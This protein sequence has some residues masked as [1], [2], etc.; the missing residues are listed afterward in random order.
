MNSV[1]TIQGIASIT[2]WLAI[3]T[4]AVWWTQKLRST[5]ENA[6]YPNKPI[7]V[8]VPFPAGGGSDTFVRILQKGIVE[9]NL[10][11]QPL[12]VI[13]QGGG[14]GT[15]GSRGVKN[16]R[17]D[18]YKIM[19][20]HNAIIT[21]KLSETVKYGPEA[22]TP[23]ALTGSMSLVI[24]VR[25]D[26]PFTNVS[27][28]VDQAKATP[29]AV[30]FGANQGA[31]AYFAALQLERSLP[32]ASFNI[33]SANGGA[34]R[35]ASLIGGHLQA[36]IFSLSE[37]LDFRS[38]EGTPAD[39]NIRAI[40]VL[41]AKR[42]E[43]IPDVMTCSEQGVPVVMSNANYW[44]APKGTS[45]EIVNHLATALE[46]AMKNKTVRSELT[47]LRVDLDYLTGAELQ[48]NLNDT[49]K[50]FESVAA[51]KQ[52]AVPDFIPWLA[53]VTGLMFL[54]M[55]AE[56]VYKPISAM[57][58]TTGTAVNSESHYIRR[59]GIAAGCFAILVAYVVSLETGLLPFAISTSIMVLST[60]L[61]MTRFRRSHWRVLLQTALLTGLGTEFVFTHIFVTALP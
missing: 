14:G 25:E 40:A 35:Y 38:P 51:R 23:I 36:A 44:W 28:L 59:P 16:S 31:P 54:W 26:S 2:I 48:A 58:L 49:I 50:S 32:G 24:I 56:S 53:T 27:E 4:L 13:N 10:L 61:L 19:C 47:R 57:G 9:D 37:Y 8:V 18:G 42:H 39:Q 1:R 55:I 17:P 30:C 6:K 7:Q 29:N 20:L 3:A 21:A 12:V 41:N 60:G 33:V 52:T 15:I 34:D 22:F 5:D 43:A 46:G 45:P 11:E